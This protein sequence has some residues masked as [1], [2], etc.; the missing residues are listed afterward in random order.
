[1]ASRILP[2][3]VALLLL[4]T[5]T[6]ALQV[7]PGSPCAALCIDGPDLD[8]FS[9]S[10]SSTNASDIVCQDSLYANSDTGEKF[11]SCLECL[12]KSD[13]TNGTEADNYWLL[14]NLRHALGTCLYGFGDEDKVINSPCIISWACEPLEDA[15]LAGDLDAGDASGDD[16]LGYCSAGNGSL[17]GSTLRSCIDCLKSSSDET[18]LG[19]CEPPPP[20]TTS[21]RAFS[22]SQT[23]TR[24]TPH[25]HGRPPGRL[26]P[27]A[28]TRRAPRHIRHALHALQPQSHDRVLL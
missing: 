14:Y 12:Q 4:T 2:T 22:Q 11:K 24:L 5:T 18:Y 10:S 25:S 26:P 28:R 7:T 19:N 17:F 21:F 9:A 23:N 15:I 6:H 3:L 13:K 16:A 20:P 1:M 27:G 8:P